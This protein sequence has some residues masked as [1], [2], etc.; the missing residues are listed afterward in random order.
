MITYFRAKV[1][2]FAT[3]FINQNL[4][5]CDVQGQHDYSSKDIELNKIENV[6]RQN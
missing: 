6:I 2:R 1:D 3:L 4:D 5:N